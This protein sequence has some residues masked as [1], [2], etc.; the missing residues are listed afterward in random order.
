MSLLRAL[1]R[2]PSRRSL[3][4]VEAAV[5]AKVGMFDLGRTC[6]SMK[7]DWAECGLVEARIIVFWVG[8]GVVAWLLVGLESPFGA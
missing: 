8:S 2:A 4:P 3:F 7:D 6:S 5:K 1:L